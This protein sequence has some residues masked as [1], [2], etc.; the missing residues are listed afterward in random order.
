[1]NHY[2]TDTLCI[3]IYKNHVFNL[4]YKHKGKQVVAPTL[5]DTFKFPSNKITEW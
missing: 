4:V 3:D 1:M 2:I 5:V